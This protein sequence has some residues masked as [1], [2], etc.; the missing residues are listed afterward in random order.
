[1]SNTATTSYTW[2]EKGKQPIIDQKQRNKERET[3][4]GCVEPKTGKVVAKRAEKG[5]NITF[6]RFLKKVLKEYKGKKVIMVLDNVRYHHAKKLKEFLECNKN[7]IELFFLPAY[8]PDLNP[9]ERIWWWMRKQITHNRY[10]EN[11]KIRI[12][13]FWELFSHYKFESTICKN[14]CNLCVKYY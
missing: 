2:A 9:M 5:N 13:K 3:I 1:L 8:S 14:L 12:G 11:L 10:I 7:R 4:F 6:K